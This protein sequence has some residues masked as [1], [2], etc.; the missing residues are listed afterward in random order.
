MISSVEA[1]ISQNPMISWGGA[2]ISLNPVI[3][4]VEAAI[5][6]D[7][8]IS[9]GGVMISLNLEISSV[10]AAISR[11]PVISW[12]V[13]EILRGRRYLSGFHDIS[14]SRD[15]PPAPHDITGGA[16]P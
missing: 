8:V 5:S 14:K 6:Q 7:A 13:L 12:R 1:A 10:E 9:W 16:T 2:M 11:N 3:S 15:I 4:L